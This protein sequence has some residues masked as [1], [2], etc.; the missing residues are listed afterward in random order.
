MCT[1]AC[2]QTVLLSSAKLLG[3]KQQKIKAKSLIVIDDCDGG[4]RVIFAY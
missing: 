3:E 1:Y 4:L 2:V